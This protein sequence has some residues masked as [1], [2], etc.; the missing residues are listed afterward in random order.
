MYLISQLSEIL[1]L[2]DEREDLSSVFGVGNETYAILGF[3][4][5]V[6]DLLKSLL[7][8][9]EIGPHRVLVYVH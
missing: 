3:E 6:E 2:G 9:G 1:V 4:A 8:K 5:L 7:D